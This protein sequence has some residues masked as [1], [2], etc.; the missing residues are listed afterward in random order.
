MQGGY[1]ISD[2]KAR[3]IVVFCEGIDDGGEIGVHAHCPRGRCLLNLRCECIEVNEEVNSG[4]GKRFHTPIMISVWIN[5]VRYT[6]TPEIVER[7]GG[8]RG[9]GGEA[10]RMTFAPSVFINAASSW[11]CVVFTNGSCGDR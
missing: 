8:G 2:E 3:E 1:L 7:L 4:F 10:H 6:S 11:H 9:G 5:M